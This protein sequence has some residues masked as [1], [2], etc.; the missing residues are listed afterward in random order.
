MNNYY[1]VQARSRSHGGSG[2]GFLAR[3]DPATAERL[4]FLGAFLREPARTGSLAPSSPDLAQAMIRGC[5]LKNARTVVEFGPGTGA[6][7]RLILQRIGRPTTFFALELDDKHVRGLRH[8][9]PGVHI[10]KDSAERIQDYL[11][12]HRRKN[13]DYIISGLPWANMPGPV[14]EQI[15]SAVV[16][17]L[18][19]EGMFTTFTYVHAFWLPRARRFR[20]RLEHYFGGIR[21][22][23]IVWR[24]MP[25]AL[26]YRCRKSA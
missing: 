8:R 6:F 14:Q 16:T 23:P 1:G 19:P 7:T 25:P 13:A 3:L 21:M 24:N 11:G 20:K 12:Q 5:D 9:F 26:V 2:S 10:H 18:A 22:S 4:Q 15:L 17:S